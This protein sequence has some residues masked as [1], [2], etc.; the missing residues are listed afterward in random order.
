MKIYVDSNH[1][2]Q[3]KVF[4]VALCFDIP[5]LQ[6]VLNRKC[7]GMYA[8]RKMQFITSLVFFTQNIVDDVNVQ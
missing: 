2:M 5:V 1:L 3:F 4:R 7:C 6:C 8:F